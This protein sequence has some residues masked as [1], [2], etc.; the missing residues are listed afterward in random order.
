MGT[1][2][3]GATLGLLESNDVRAET[4]GLGQ[5]FLSD[6]VTAVHGQPFVLR[7]E[8]PPATLG[9]GLVIQPLARRIRRRDA[10][11]VARLRQLTDPQPAARVATALGFAGL[12]AAT[13]RSLACDTGLAEVE[14]RGVV[15]D[16]AASGHLVE[17]AIGP[18]RTTHLIADTVRDLEDRELRTLGRLHA[19]SPRQAAVVRSRVAAALADLSNDALVDAVID[20]LKARGQVT[21]EGRTVALADHVPKLTQK[22]RE[23]KAE[24]ARTL[25]AA[26]LAPP[27]PDELAAKAGPRASAIPDL[28]KLLVDEERLVEISPQLYLDY[29]VAGELRRRVTE[30]LFDGSAITMAELRDMLG[31]TRRYAVP[32]GEYLDRIGLTVREGDLRRLGERF[33]AGT[34]AIEG[35]PAS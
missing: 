20:R 16:L 14:V 32:I 12:A 3:V 34:G 27:G 35:G 24:I 4:P 6:P 11:T 8:S 5:L 15:G 30:R 7:E 23:L 17:I 19:A 10:A 26:G 29:D 18:R 28:L 25:S 13:D 9:G 2:E 33:P 1:A 21:T 22:E 31:T